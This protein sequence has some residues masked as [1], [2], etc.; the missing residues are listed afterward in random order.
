MIVGVAGILLLS[1][2]VGANGAAAARGV[3]GKVGESAVGTC[4][5][6]L[7]ER[8]FPTTCWT[9]LRGPPVCGSNEGV[10]EAGGQEA[11]G[12]KYMLPQ[13]GIHSFIWFAI[14]SPSFFSFFPG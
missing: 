1:C 11:H 10:A 4:G 7:P 14:F 6:L 2:P 3:D 9:L 5:Q 12:P 13:F 8:A